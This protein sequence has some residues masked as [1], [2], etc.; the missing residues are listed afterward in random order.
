MNAYQKAVSD[1]ITPLLQAV[2][3]GTARH[4]RSL[5]FVWHRCHHGRGRL[6]F[7]CRGILSQSQQS[8]HGRTGTLR[9]CVGFHIT[10]MFSQT[11]G[12]AR[13]IPGQRT[14]TTWVLILSRLIRAGWWR[15]LRQVWWAVVCS[16]LQGCRAQWTKVRL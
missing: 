4:G 9:S 2:L 8:L 14:A 15:G 16:I 10:A 1:L 11:V 12:W 5:G 6:R 13:S 3:L 7:F